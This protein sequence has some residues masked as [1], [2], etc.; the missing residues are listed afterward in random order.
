[1]YKAL[2]FE[3]MP[4]HEKLTKMG[5]I[6]GKSAGDLFELWSKEMTAAERSAERKT[7]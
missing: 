1:M 4:D 3:R 7:A 2:R 6:L 5:K